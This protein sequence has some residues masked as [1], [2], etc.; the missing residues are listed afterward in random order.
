MSENL[1][2]QVEV[3]AQAASPGMARRRLIRAGLA[4]APVVLSLS[5]RSAMATVSDGCGPKGLSPLA[6][7]SISPGANGDCIALSRQPGRNTLGR[8]PGF[9]QP[10]TG[11]SANVFQGAW[12]WNKSPAVKPFSAYQGGSY[13]GILSNDSRWATGTQFGTVIPTL[14][15]TLVAG[16]T[17][18]SGKT[19]ATS[20]I[21]RLLID[22]N[23]SPIPIKLA[24]ALLNALTYSGYAMTVAEVLF[25]A[26]NKQL[27]AG[28]PT[29][30]DA[31][32][33]EF[34]DQTWS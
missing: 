29:L 26:A 12:P 6:W 13:T 30:S 14:H 5:G 2:S 19:V 27:V 4:A 16:T 10:N 32:I 15:S 21:S 7:N 18:Q 20:S 28:G 3:V 8:S 34:L 25:L 23:A 24:C 31:T 9:W 22:N 17:V 1:S 11:P 33:R